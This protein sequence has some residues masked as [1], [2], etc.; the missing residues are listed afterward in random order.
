MVK[1]TYIAC[2]LVQQCP[3][4]ACPVKTSGCSQSP[5]A[6]NLNFVDKKSHVQKEKLNTV[7]LYGSMGR[8]L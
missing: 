7:V 3:S 2:L 5:L 6:A 4:S 1:E 8:S